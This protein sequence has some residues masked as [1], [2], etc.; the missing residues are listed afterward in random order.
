MALFGKKKKTEPARKAFFV[1]TDGNDQNQGTLDAPFATLDTA[2]AMSRM[3]TEPTTVFIR[4]GRYFLTSTVELNEKDSGLIICAYEDEEVILDGGAVLDPSDLTLLSTEE[5]KRIIDM[6]ARERIFKINIKPYRLSKGIYGTRGFRRAYVNAPNELFVDGETYTVTSY[7][8]R[9]EE[10]I[11]ITEK[12]LVDAGSRPYDKDF[13]LRPAKIKIPSEKAK[14]WKGA[15]DAYICGYFGSSYADDAIKL[16]E[17]NDA[18]STVT[19]T[20][21]HIYSFTAG[22]GHHYRILNLLEEISRPGEYYVDTQN[23]ILYLYPKKNLSMSLIQISSLDRVMMSVENATNIK[24]Q[25]II[26]ENGRNSGLYIEGGDGVSVEGCT[27]RNLGVLGIQIGCGATA[28]P[29]GRHTAHGERDGGVPTPVNLSRNMGNWH[30]FLYEFAAWNN[31][32][33][34]NHRIVNCKIYDTGAGGMLLSGG[35]RKSLTPAHNTVYNCYFARNNRL[36]RTYA[37][38]INVM[39][40]GNVITHC[41][42]EDLPSVA[43]YLHGN[44]HEI[45]YN[46]IHNVVKEVSDMGAFYMG[47]DPSEVGNVIHNNFF[48]DIMSSYTKGFGI[49]ALYFDDQ[50]IYNAAYANVFY[51]VNTQGTYNFD[52]IHT[53]MG[54]MV[55]VSSNYFIDCACNPTAKYS[56]NAYMDMNK[57]PL[58]MKRVHTKDPND[59]SGVDVTSSVWKKKYPYLYRTYKYNYNAGTLY[60]NNEYI[61]LADRYGKDVRGEGFV[62]VKDK[63]F[64]LTDKE[65]SARRTHKS[66]VYVTD[67][68]LG[69]KNELVPFIIP[70]FENMGMIEK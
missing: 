11:Y 35:D 39:G 24:I 55:S 67:P 66:E 1:A 45:S 51:R 49:T 64:K 47:R 18:D 61:N 19:T 70:D 33:G 56:G 23:D 65:T 5:K 16:K 36:N 37:G 52:V 38:A 32:G 20:L 30:E 17:I 59:F 54:G 3:S 29:E 12:N 27:F 21:P 4:G 57:R 22:D 63:N 48:Y 7:P 43:I 40:V 14:A 53:N 42:I 6:N 60:Y 44:D 26:F 13:T 28:M 34:K 9:D 31:N 8:R 62:S 15:D 2:I 50:A 10:P 68:V 46:R 69:Y 41:E 25:G 58:F